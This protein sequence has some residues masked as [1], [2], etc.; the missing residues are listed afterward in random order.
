MSAQRWVFSGLMSLVMAFLMTAWVSWIHL[1]FGPD[2]LV[3][4]MTAFVQAWPVALVIALL[5]GTP[6]QRL[7][8]WCVARW[9]H[10]S[11]CKE[12]RG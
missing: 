8:A 4:W 11:S 7:S 2:F 1:G 12:T 6:L 10:R 3:Q 5:A 9:S